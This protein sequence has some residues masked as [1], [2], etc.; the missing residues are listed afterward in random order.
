MLSD[1]TPSTSAEKP[2]P[3]SE[4]S[5]DWD[6]VLLIIT[7][8]AQGVGSQSHKSWN[9]AARLYQISQKYQLDS[10]RHWFTE[11]C[12]FWLHEQPLEALILAC[13]RPEIDEPLVQH[14]IVSLWKADPNALYNANPHLF[15]TAMPITLPMAP[16]ATIGDLKRSLLDASNIT[17]KLGVALGYK[18]SLA[19]NFAFAGLA[20]GSGGRLDTFDEWQCLSLRFLSA[21][22]VVG[23]E[24]TMA[25][26]V[27]P[28][29]YAGGRWKKWRPST[30]RLTLRPSPSVIRSLSVV[31][32]SSCK[33]PGGQEQRHCKNN[34]HHRPMRIRKVN[35]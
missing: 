3:L 23:H 28:G 15:R 18:G 31:R 29:K 13:D 25:R 20:T 16:Y 2:L 21:L 33:S 30:A 19:Y 1:S 24:I 12:V 17:L 22:R 26:I 14:A 11:I 6:I 32:Q 4:S 7:G 10:H 8:R 34:R 5:E 27:S 35:E 9:Q